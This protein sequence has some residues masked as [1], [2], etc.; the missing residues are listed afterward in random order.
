MTE[1]RSFT[2]E[3]TGCWYC[4]DAKHATYN[5]IVCR[6]WCT[7]AKKGTD[8]EQIFIENCNGITPS[9][10]MWDKSKPIVLV[11]KNVGKKK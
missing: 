2:F 10:P 1:Q 3:V 8:S 4:P 11:P 5:D 7:N 9:C 6:S